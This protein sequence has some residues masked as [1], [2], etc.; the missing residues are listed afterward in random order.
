MI[1]GLT[2]AAPTTDL[3]GNPRP[4]PSGTN[5]DI[6][7]IESPESAPQVGIAAVTTDNGFCQTTSGAITANLLNYTGI[8]AFL[9]LSHV[10]FS[11]FF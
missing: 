10:Y 11:F 7:A 2:L 3:F 8:S 6:G 4:K 9:S 1:S 5:P